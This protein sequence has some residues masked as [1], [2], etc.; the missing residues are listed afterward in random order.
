MGFFLV[1]SITLHTRGVTIPQVAVPVL[2]LYGGVFQSLV[3]MW[4]M[5]LGNT[6]GATVFSSY[7]A[8]NLTYGALY[9]PAFG[10]AAAYTLPDGSLSPQ[11]EQA[12]GLYLISWFIVTMLFV[13]GALRSSGA[14]L[15]TL[16]FTA[17]AFLLLAVNAFNPSDAARIAGGSFGMLASACAFWG[18]MCGFWVKDTTYALFTPSPIDLTPKSQ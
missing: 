2:I 6:F 7:G 4:E 14:V 12:I 9:L 3:G 8:F 11:F 16:I 18:A 15:S 10:V 17:L 1:S 13:I 5:F